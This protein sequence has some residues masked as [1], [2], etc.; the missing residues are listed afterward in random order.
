M[1]VKCPIE[2]IDLFN[3]QRDIK[4][5]LLKM[6]QFSSINSDKLRHSFIDSL[7]LYVYQKGERVLLQNEKINNTIYIIKRGTFSL[8]HVS[9]YIKD[10]YFNLDYF[11]NYQEEQKDNDRFI[12]FRNYELKG[13]FSYLDNEKICL[14]GRGEI[15]GDIEWM[16]KKEVSLFNIISN[17]NNSEIL[18][19][20]RESFENFTKKIPQKTN[21][22]IEAKIHN[23]L[24]RIKQLIEEKKLCT[25]NP[26]KLSFENN[27][28]KQIEFNHLKIKQRL[29]LNTIHNRKLKLV[30]LNKTIIASSAQKP[31]SNSSSTIT[32]NN[33]RTSS[34][35]STIL[36]STCES[37]KL[38]CSF[39]CLSEK[40]DRAKKTMVSEFKLNVLELKKNAT[41]KKKG[42]NRSAINIKQRNEKFPLINKLDNSM[43]LQ[44]KGK[45]VL[46]VK[47]SHLLSHNEEI[48]ND[49]KS[50]T[51]RKTHRRKISNPVLLGKN[52]FLNQKIDMLL[53]DKYN[54]LRQNSSE[55]T[56]EV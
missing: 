51:E 43:F 12:S 35:T 44:N 47:K 19:C 37:S 54:F 21:R 45:L 40:K 17:E 56:I 6:T 28:K 20:D 10:V 25:A 26:M 34:L 29:Q 39:N 8:T 7:H 15:I 5:L 53:K 36:R 9:K 13:N 49:P 14:L 55:K 2:G 3:Q 23:I 18:T 52:L 38:D 1:Q 46:N 42:L 16:M 32:I 22:I 27:L 30:K 11:K 33:N 24:N 48:E 31:S 50:L 4:D 41:V